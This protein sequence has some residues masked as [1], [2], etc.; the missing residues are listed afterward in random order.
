MQ[1]EDDVF[2]HGTPQADL[3]SSTRPFTRCPA[4][5]TFERQR[6]LHSIRRNSSCVTC[7]ACPLIRNV[8]STSTTPTSASDSWYGRR[9]SCSLTPSA[10]RALPACRRP[11]RSGRSIPPTASRVRESIATAAGFCFLVAIVLT[12][13]C[14]RSPQSAEASREEDEELSAGR[15]RDDAAG[16]CPVCDGRA[17]PDAG[18]RSCRCH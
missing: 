10:G 5:S 6:R 12:A 2:L 15:L 17:H 16:R 9:R 14:G 7:S 13:A 4:G 3:L 8:T 18:G 1:G 11:R